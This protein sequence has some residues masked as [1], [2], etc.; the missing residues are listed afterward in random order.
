MTMTQKRMSRILGPRLMTFVDLKGE[1][2]NLIIIPNTEWIDRRYWRHITKTLSV[3]GYSWQRY[4]QR[5]EYDHSKNV[6]PRGQKDQTS[7][8]SQLVD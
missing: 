2:K 5:W 4:R 8:N 7:K 1:D 6:G 3:Y